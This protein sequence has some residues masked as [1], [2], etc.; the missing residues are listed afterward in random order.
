MPVRETFAAIARAQPASS[1]QR[2]PRD[3]TRR[4][5]C[6]PCNAGKIIALDVIAN[7]DP[8][9]FA[10]LLGALETPALRVGDKKVA[11]CL[12]AR[13]GLEFLRIDEVGVKRDRIGV[14]EK[15]HEPAIAAD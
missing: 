15:L 7:S 6:Q 2:A 3:T 14:A 4:W 9:A 10:R 12:D 8:P 13:H 5:A 11:K 1:M